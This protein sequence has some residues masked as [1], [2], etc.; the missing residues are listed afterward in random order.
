MVFTVAITTLPIESFTVAITTNHNYDKRLMLKIEPGGM[1]SPFRLRAL[2]LSTMH[3]TQGT[4]DGNSTGS[5]DTPK[6]C[7]VTIEFR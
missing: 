4:V 3:T 6:Y 5:G 2:P 7:W 1:H